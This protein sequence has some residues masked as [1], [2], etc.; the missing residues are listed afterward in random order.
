MVYNSIPNVLQRSVVLLWT[1]V[2]KAQK[3]IA[4]VIVVCSILT[5]KLSV[6]FF[7]GIPMK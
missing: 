2:A 6:H 1:P 4:G 7:G 3:K 5:T